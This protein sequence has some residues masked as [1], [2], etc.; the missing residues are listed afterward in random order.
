M[1]HEDSRRR[2]TSGPRPSRG[3]EPGHEC[4]PKKKWEFAK[5]AEETEGGYES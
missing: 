2:G 5:G 4:T 3:H 1:T